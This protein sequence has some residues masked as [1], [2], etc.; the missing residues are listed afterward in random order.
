[1]TTHPLWWLAFGIIVLATPL[2]IALTWG[3]PLADI[4]YCSLEAARVLAAE[5]ELESL[6]QGPLLIFLLAVNPANAPTFGLLFSAFGWSAAAVTLFY[7]FH[8]LDR[9][10]AGIVSA[11]LISISPAIISTAGTAFS[12]VVALGWVALTMSILAPSPPERRWSIGKSII[13]ILIFLLHFDASTVLFALAVLLLDLY[14]KRIRWLP[15]LLVTAVAFA[16]GLLA[17]QHFGLSATSDPSFWLQHIPLLVA[18][19]GQYWLF[20]PFILTGLVEIWS[21]KTNGIAGQ[22]LQTRLALSRGQQAFLLALIWTAVTII[23]GTPLITAVLPVTAIALISLGVAWLIDQLL[24]RNQLILSTARSRKTLLIVFALSLLGVQALSL[25]QRYMAR[26]EA[27]L[28]LEAQAATWLRENA[29]VEATLFAAPHLGYLAE[30]TTIPEQVA[31]VTA[32]NVADLHTMLIEEEPDYIV[33]Q[34]TLPW[35]YVIRSGWF[36]ERYVQLQ[37]FDNDYAP[38][39]PLTIWQNKPSPFERAVHQEVDTVVA[40]KFALVGYQFEPQVIHPGDDLSLT[41]DFQALQPVENGFMTSIH[42]VAHDGLIW[43]Y[44]DEP[45]PRSVPGAWW[46]PEQVIPERFQIE[47]PADLP[48]GA[49]RV[50]VFWHTASGDEN[51]PVSQDGDENILDRVRLGYIILPPAVD[52][53]QATPVGAKFADNILLEALEVGSALPGEPLEV[54]LYW[55]TISQPEADYTVLVSLLDPTGE[56]VTIHNSMPVDNRI[57]TQAFIPGNIVR[58]AHILDLPTDMQPGSY[59]LFTGLYLLETGE[60]LPVRSID[61]LEPPDRVLKLTEVEIG[62]SQ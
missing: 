35:D 44:R 43:A 32:N 60:R 16:W 12:W 8:V 6:S 33:S 3:T 5:F 23:S 59:Q 4:A 30:R 18:E 19:K 37:M 27:Q 28:T 38:D 48:L 40:D 21:W 54:A 56:V 49:Y 22:D 10:A 39:G 55:D 62:S 45:T 47:I 57:P 26:S 29:A 53:Q 9:P 41:L 34:Q 17:I 51:W 11:L 2:V 24:L 15:F 7:I 61:G 42:L 50:E 25:W 58:D 13:F 20:V 14:E 46:Q 31:H 52:M 1:M 36:K